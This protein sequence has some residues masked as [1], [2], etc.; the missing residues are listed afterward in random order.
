M[1]VVLSKA[2]TN[3]LKCRSCGHRIKNG[4]DVLFYV[5]KG[6]LD[7]VNCLNCDSG[8]LELRVLEEEKILEDVYDIGQD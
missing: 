7:S 8:K 1:D 6:H 4:E 2:R 3:K 5:H